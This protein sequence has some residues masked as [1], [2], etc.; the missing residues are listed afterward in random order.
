MPD[1]TSPVRHQPPSS[2][3]DRLNAA[4][5]THD[6]RSIRRNS[7]SQSPAEPATYLFPL[8]LS[9]SK[10]KTPCVQSDPR[11]ENRRPI[12]HQIRFRDRLFAAA[13]YQAAD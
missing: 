13:A 11:H 8:I 12:T 5:H 2:P 9:L 6:G 1:P 10:E 7:V 4:P 3:H